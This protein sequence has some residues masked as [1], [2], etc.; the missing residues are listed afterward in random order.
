MMVRTNLLLGFL[1]ALFIGG[2]SVSG[3][4]RAQ[5]HAGRD[6]PGIQLLKKADA[7]VTKPRAKDHTSEVS[8]APTTRIEYLPAPTPEEARVL[9]LLR[10]RAS[11]QLDNVTLDKFVRE[12][13]QATG[14]DVYLDRRELED[15]DIF[16]DKERGSLHLKNVEVRQ[17]LR[18]IMDQLELAYQVEGNT[19]QITS[20]EKVEEILIFR[21]YLVKD[22][23]EQS[24][25]TIDGNWLVELIENTIEVDSWDPVGS[26]TIAAYPQ[27]YVL[28]VNQTQDCHEQVL[29]M[30]RMLRKARDLAGVSGADARFFPGGQKRSPTLS[31]PVR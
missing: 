17:A 11:F 31:Q 29:H 15:F 3:V 8:D 23:M 6:K 2:G 16:A 9:D 26:G 19:L 4:L 27:A 13:S 30:L 14:F 20:Q 25:G 1:T 22:L 21:I 7:S 5:L 12:L 24:G 10:A 18:L 28:A